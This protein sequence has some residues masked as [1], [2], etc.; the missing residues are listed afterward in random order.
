MEIITIITGNKGVH[1]YNK[2]LPIDFCGISQTK[3]FSCMSV[4]ACGL[5]IAGIDATMS[6]RGSRDMDLSS[7]SN[8]SG[9]SS[10][11]S[12]DSKKGSRG[13]ETKTDSVATPNKRA[14]SPSPPGAP[15]KKVKTEHKRDET[16]TEW[17]DAIDLTADEPE[18]ATALLD[19][20]NAESQRDDLGSSGQPATPGGSRMGV[21]L[22]LGAQG[23]VML[24]GLYNN[25]H[26]NLPFCCISLDCNHM[27]RWNQCPTCD[28]GYLACLASHEVAV[29]II[30]LET[31]GGVDLP[32]PCFECA[33][34]VLQALL[35]FFN[36]SWTYLDGTVVLSPVWPVCKLVWSY[37][38][39]SIPN[40]NSGTILELFRESYNR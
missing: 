32:P 7:G 16:K 25:Y 10:S 37:C 19:L 13:R 30:D 23:T 39:F 27:R 17:V 14:R 4:G 9:S 26:N 3:E 21:L 11:R 29:A 5:Y 34:G 22:G 15:V 20:S 36:R 33:S 6:S 40:S 18:L 38:D 28:W 8:S 31:F 24:K 12:L 35:D 1:Y 2:R